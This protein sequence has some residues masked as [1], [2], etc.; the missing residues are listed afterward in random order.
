MPKIYHWLVNFS[1]NT[2]TKYVRA[3]TFPLPNKQ[4]GYK[5]EWYSN[6]SR[7]EFEGYKLEVESSYLE[8]L[9]NEFGDFMTLPPV[10]KRK[11][12]PVTDLRFPD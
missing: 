8:W 7:I 11:V 4:I 12:H 1:K 10:E 6:Y 9:S 2:N 5:R 3:L